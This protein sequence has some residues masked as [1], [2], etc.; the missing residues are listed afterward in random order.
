MDYKIIKFSDISEDKWNKEISNLTGHT[1]L[2]NSISIKYYTAFKNILNKSF[3]LEVEKKTLAAVPLS[4]NKN[5]KK[6]FFGYNFG[7]C[8]SPIYRSDITP[9]MRRKLIHV[10]IDEIKKIG[11]NKIVDLN[12][13]TH[14][15]ST[16]KYSEITSK[17]QFYFL[18]LKPKFNVINTLIL[19]LNK[20]EE[21][22]FDNLSKYHKRNIVRSK[23]KNL[24]FNFYNN[25]SD[26]KII[27]EKFIIFKKLHF[28][29]SG[30]L[31]RPNKTWDIMYDQILKNKAD[32]FS[33]SVL[34]KDISFLY[35]G[36]FHDFAWGWSQV[37]DQRYEKEYMPRHLLE[38][39][40]ILYYKKNLFKYYEIGERFFNQTNNQ[41][42]KKEISISEF[43]EKYGSDYY[44][45]A[46]FKINL[47]KYE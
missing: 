30:K 9:S 1:H 47:D 43:K 5:L 24:K 14:P 17:N 44:P 19:E 7:F 13:F 12:F 20:K 15:I 2:V 16:S 35:C 42:T 3:L 45:K 18:S 40:S 25:T 21:V 31:T 29:S 33:I 38:W 6:N 32:L 46:F 36:K 26:K 22:I 10:I 8:P 23:K 27:K 4:I 37:N 39:E 41:I 11:K 28:K 34:N